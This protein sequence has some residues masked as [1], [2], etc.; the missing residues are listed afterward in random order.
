MATVD[1]K[2]LDLEGLK[3]YNN[4]V[5]ELIDDKVAKEAGT[6]V[7]TLGAYKI[8]TNADGLVTE[9]AALSYNDLQDKPTIGNGTLTLQV[10]GTSVGTFTANA[11]DDK[12]LNI[13]LGDFGLKGAMHFVGTS[14]TDPMGPTGATVDGY[15]SFESGDVVLYNT[16]EFVYNGAK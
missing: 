8:A 4:K 15:S 5:K 9:T 14:T 12:I 16:K 13:K 3:T 10:N 2:Y 7:N 11:V 1:K 6:E